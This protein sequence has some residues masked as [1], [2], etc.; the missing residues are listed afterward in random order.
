MLVCIRRQQLLQKPSRAAIRAHTGAEAGLALWQCLQRH[1]RK[2]VHSCLAIHALAI[3]L[4]GLRD[5]AGGAVSRV[6]RARLHHRRGGGLG[7]ARGRRPSSNLRVVGR[8]Q[9]QV[10]QKV[11]HDI[12]RAVSQR[13]RHL[14][15]TGQRGSHLG[16]RRSWVAHM[17]VCLPEVVLWHE[18]GEAAAQSAGI[19][20]GPRPEAVPR[21]KVI[22]AVGVGAARPLGV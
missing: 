15:E 22:V 16:P 20:A 6:P 18:G 13:T 8:E 9:V 5:H 21:I 19:G 17:H 4:L 14:C 11:L 1:G 12:L 2:G 7:G 10:V 3:L